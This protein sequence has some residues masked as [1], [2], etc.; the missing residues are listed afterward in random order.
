MSTET[1]KLEGWQIKVSH[2][3]RFVLSAAGEFY[4]TRFEHPSV[5]PEPRGGFTIATLI[6]PDKTVLVQGTAH[7]SRRDNYS[8][9]LGRNI[10]VGRALSKLKG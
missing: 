4:G 9:K 5:P 6:S 10:A 1:L 3:R 2:N 7:C 8:K